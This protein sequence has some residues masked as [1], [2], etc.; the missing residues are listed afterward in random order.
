MGWLYIF[1]YNET[2]GPTH[3]YLIEQVAFTGNENITSSDIVK[4]SLN[5]PVKSLYWVFINDS[6]LKMQYLVIILLNIVHHLKSSISSMKLLF[7]GQ[8]HLRRLFILELYNIILIIQIP[9][10]HIY[11]YSFA[12]KHQPSGTSNFLE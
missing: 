2:W 7:N 1:R 11:A 5:H 9:S 3:E 6:N 8:N 12:L 4:K 10:K